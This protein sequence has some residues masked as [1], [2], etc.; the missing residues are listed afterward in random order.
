MSSENYQS[1][2]R[3][4]LFM[5]LVAG[6]CGDQILSAMT[7]SEVT[8]SIFPLIALVLALQAL[9]TDYLHKPASEDFPLLGLA[10]FFV[11]AFGHSAFLKAQYPHEGSNFISIMVALVLTAWVVKKLGSSSKTKA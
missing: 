3:K 11:G 10:C 9:Y 4:N 5:A 2:E 6:I 8:F 7:M 1:S